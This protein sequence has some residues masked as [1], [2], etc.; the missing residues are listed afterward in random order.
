MNPDEPMPEVSCAFHVAGSREK[1]W[2]RVDY[3][4]MD[5]VVLRLYYW[6]SI[7]PFWVL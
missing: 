5:S 3:A 2:R 7:S 1:T 6:G 4:T